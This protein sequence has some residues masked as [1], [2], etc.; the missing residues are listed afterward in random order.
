MCLPALA[1]SILQ[2]WILRKTYLGGGCFLNMMVRAFGFTA[3][4]CG[5]NVAGGFYTHMLTVLP[6]LLF[7]C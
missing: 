7:T 3:I 6:P 4:L 5:A 2:P 1:F